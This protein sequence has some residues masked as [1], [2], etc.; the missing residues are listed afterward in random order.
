MVMNVP[1][2]ADLNLIQQ[3]RQQI[4][5]KRLLIGNRQRFSH[6]YYP[7]QEVLKLIDEPDKVAPRALG[8]NRIHTVHSNR[9]LTL[10]MTPN[11]HVC[12][13]IRKVKQFVRS[14]IGRPPHLFS[15]FFFYR[16]LMMSGLLTSSPRRSAPSPVRRCF[17]VVREGRSVAGT[18]FI[19]PF[20]AGSH[21]DRCRVVRKVCR[22]PL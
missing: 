14:E 1:F 11:M 19:G 12:I 10:Q 20:R 7:N 2:I 13:S 8:P 18:G 15:F 9:T 4:I 3:H 21:R 16:H 5:D 22:C 6:D 17:V